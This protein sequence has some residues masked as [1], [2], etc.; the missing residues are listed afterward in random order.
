MWCWFYDSFSRGLCAP[1]DP[2]AA[3][4][5]FTGTMWPT[6]LTCENLFVNLAAAQAAAVGP[7]ERVSPACSTRPAG[8]PCRTVT[9]AVAA[10]LQIVPATAKDTSTGLYPPFLAAITRRRRLA[11][12]YPAWMSAAAPPAG[13]AR[14]Y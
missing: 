4:C 7:P 12:A 2:A 14:W 11:P 6:R 3:D 1:G 10:Q 5:V 9:A 8:W 13:P